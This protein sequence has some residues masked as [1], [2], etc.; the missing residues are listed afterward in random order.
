MPVG[1]NAACRDFLFVVASGL[2]LALV[3]STKAGMVRT[4]YPE[5]MGCERGC[6]VAS[7]GWPIPYLIDY[8]G[9]S[10]VGSA[11]L[12]GA[13]VGEDKFHAGWFGVTSLFWIAAAAAT[14]FLW[15][16][17]RLRVSR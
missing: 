12:M 5:I 10:V 14:L 11:D 4:L 1:Y 13:L 15:R 8:P 16:R 7:A 9:I 6:E 17:M 2:M 3:S